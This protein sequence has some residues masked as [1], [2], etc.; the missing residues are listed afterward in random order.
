MVLPFA[1]TAEPLQL[2]VD[3]KARAVIVLADRPS[4]AARE[5]AELLVAQLERISAARLSVVSESSLRDV[6]VSANSIVAT[7]GSGPVT[8]FVLVGE[9][10]LSRQLGATAEGLGAGGIL[11]RTTPN[12]LILL[13]PDDQTPA[14]PDGTRYAVTTFLDESLGFRALWPG[15]LGLVAPPRRTVGVPSIDRQFTPLIAQRKIRSSSYNNRVQLGLEYL[16]VK[17]ADYDRNFA[18]AFSGGP[19]VPDWFKWQRLGGSIGLVAGHAYGYTWEK[20][21]GEHPE[22][23]ALQANG[24]RD[25]TKLVPER[26]RLCKSNLALIEAL[27]RDKIAE[28]DRNGGR[29]V[30]LSPNDGGRATFCMCAECKK[31]DPPE[32]RAIQLW[33]LIPSPRRE[34]DYVSLTDRMVWFW[35]QLAT[36][37]A[38]QHPKATLTVYAYSAYKAPP[39]REK[40]HPNIA[41]GFVGLNYRREAERQQ[42]RADWDAWSQATKKLYW[43]PNLLLF[44]R[45]EGTP[46]LYAHKLGEDVTYFAHHSLLGTDFDSCMHHWSTEGVNY[47]VLARLLWNPDANVDTIL[48]DYCLSGFGTA[49]GTVR[50]YLVRIEQI[51]HQIAENDFTVTA[52]YTPDRTS[53]LSALLAEAD[54]VNSD[55]TVRRRIAFL[56]RGL[57]FTTLQ[58]RAH[59]YLAR[60]AV[61][62]LT[63]LEKRELAAV[64][65]EKWFF[66]R[67]LFREEP[68][69]VNVPQV[70]W[71]SEGAFGKLGWSGA[72]SVSKEI[73][74]ADEDGRP[75]EAPALR[76]N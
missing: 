45:R 6:S 67:R 20:Y 26:A 64:Q 9:S 10:A 55:E 19:K 36:R 2:I 73:V 22:W 21:H 34:F 30:S 54:R 68:L 48:D 17:K 53:E 11:I 37:I 50:R 71:G 39:V 49:A 33:D 15:E 58:H 23:F 25:L 13:G 57:E 40:L 3:G 7:T 44:S 66:M 4:Q 12:A 60:H 42:A 31:L 16:G 56:R 59:Q 62:P 5:G 72:K 63:S 75:V 69:A 65:Q 61:T 74:D 76:A 47:Y 8:A 29:G 1:A 32:G 14:D 24:S 35:N 43:R 27:A 51:T 28:L 70:A 18:Q 41:V 38:A 46:S 52:P